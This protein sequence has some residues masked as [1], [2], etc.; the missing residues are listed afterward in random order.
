MYSSSVDCMRRRP[1][2]RAN[3][4]EGF[5]LVEMLVSV[6]IFALISL[7][8]YDGLELL[9]KARGSADE[10][11]LRSGRSDL[12]LAVMTQDLLHLRSRVIRDSLGEFE[13]AYVAPGGD[14]LL[15]FSRGGLPPVPGSRGGLQ[16]VA[17]AVDADRTLRRAVWPA[18]DLGGDLQPLRQVLLQDVREARF[19][20]LD[21]KGEWH[22]SWPPVNRELPADYLPRAVRVTVEMHSGERL[23]LLVPG[24][25]YA[26]AEPA[27]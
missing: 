8:A 18:V 12:A 24:L 15:R 20:Q 4:A 22:R 10:E 16:R 13:R 2:A 23:R 21:A 26:F 1:R 3:P 7:L 25:E 19:E 6:L 11:Y 5:T 9:I 14:Y 17:Y 27:P